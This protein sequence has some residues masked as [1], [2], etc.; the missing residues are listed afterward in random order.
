MNN[1]SLNRF[2]L[3]VKK[4]FIETYKSNLITNILIIII[5]FAVY[6]IF[7][8]SFN[9]GSSVHSA[10]YH[11]TEDISDFFKL[12]LI[13]IGIKLA[14]G[15]FSA[16]RKKEK[17]F[18]Y[19]SLP[20]SNIEK[21]LSNFFINIIIF[22]II[23]YLIFSICGILCKYFIELSNSHVTILYYNEK[24][25]YQAIIWNLN[26][27]AIFL[28]GSLKFNSNPIFKTLLILIVL[29]FILIKAN[30]F[31][32]TFL[33]NK[34]IGIIWDELGRNSTIGLQYVYLSKLIPAQILSYLFTF[35]MPLLLWFV[36]FLKFKEKE[37]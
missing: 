18:M 36:A 23:F 24:K 37:I 1:F 27:S 17:G 7:S 28:L 3:V 5:I 30:Y 4:E 32:I 11:S 31:I 25:Y 26:L 15:S 6:A 20:A 9:V 21:F 2:A 22:P 34:G 10:Y 12:G 13:I 19:L 14:G 29:L 35:F 8:I 16:L 33:E